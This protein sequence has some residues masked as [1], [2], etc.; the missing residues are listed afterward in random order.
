MMIDY[1]ILKDATPIVFV[2]SALL[3]SMEQ[4][5]NFFSPL[6]FI[7]LSI[8]GCNPDIDLNFAALEAD[9]DFNEDEVINVIMP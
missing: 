9:A 6:M 3:S 1:I 4:A 5:F 8:G 7:S 2:Q